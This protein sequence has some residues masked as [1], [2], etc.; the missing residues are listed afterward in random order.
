VDGNSPVYQCP[1]DA[2]IAVLGG[3]WKL[4]LLFYI[5]QA[6][7]RNGELTRLVPTITQKM[8]TQQLRELEADGILT[9]TVYEEVPARVIYDIV[10]ASVPASP[11]CSPRYVTGA[12]TGATKPVR[13]SSPW[14]PSEGLR[15]DRLEFVMR[16]GRQDDA[17]RIAWVNLT[18]RDD[19]GHHTGL[20]DQVA[21]G[22]A[23]QN[24]F[25]KTRL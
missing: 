19:D 14:R 16:F 6:P 21:F 3:R 17:N 10:P 22:V 7:R 4:V 13:T 24:R 1:V 18:A 9:R 15:S 23:V 8:L 20:A 2:P 5:L 12:C 11:T 25:H